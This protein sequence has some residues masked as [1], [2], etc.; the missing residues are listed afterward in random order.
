MSVETKEN[1]KIFERADILKAKDNRARN[2][3]A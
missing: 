1:F 3:M 2:P